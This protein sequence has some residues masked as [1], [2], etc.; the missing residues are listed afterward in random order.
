MMIPK[1][2]MPMLLKSLQFVIDVAEEKYD[3][4]IDFELTK[5]DLELV[6]QIHDRAA[7]CL[8]GDAPFLEIE[9]CYA[10]NPKRTVSGT[11]YGYKKPKPSV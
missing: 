11:M 9:V 6:K 10:N 7:L 2:K 4:P 8:H 1:S 5:E 3:P